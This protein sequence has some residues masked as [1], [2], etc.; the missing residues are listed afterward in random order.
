MKELRREAQSHQHHKILSRSSTA[1]GRA[2]SKSVVVAQQ[3]KTFNLRT[4]KLH[5][6][7]DYTT[8][9]KMFGTLDSYLTQSARIRK[10]HNSFRATK[11]PLEPVPDVPEEC[12]NVRKSQHRPIDLADFIRKNSGD[13]ALQTEVPPPSSHQG[14][15][16]TGL[17]AKCIAATGGP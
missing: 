6:L 2:P 9:I 1:P 14:N 3:S 11:D 4:Y 5:A 7:S 8:T 10:I 12:Y 13:P 15:A 16:R 17:R